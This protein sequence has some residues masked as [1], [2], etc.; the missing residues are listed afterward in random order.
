MKVYRWNNEANEMKRNFVNFIEITEKKGEKK[1]RLKKIKKT[2][3]KK[4]RKCVFSLKIM[5]TKKKHFNK[6]IV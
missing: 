5:R 2:L 4:Q 6:I 3:D 1:F